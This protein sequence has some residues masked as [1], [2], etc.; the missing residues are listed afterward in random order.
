MPDLPK[1]NGVRSFM[2]ER[3]VD[4]DTIGG[5]LKLGSGFQW[6]ALCRLAGI[7]ARERHQPGGTE[8][9]DYL[10][11]LMF[12]VLW[13]RRTPE[14]TVAALH[15]DKYGGRFDALVY[16]PNG[17]VLN[18]QLVM[19]GYAIPW[20]GQGGRPLPEWPIPY[21][22]EHAWQAVASRPYRRWWPDARRRPAYS[23][24]LTPRGTY[25]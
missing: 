5:R 23:V 4:G 22:R 18:D 24:P 1:D 14:L 7:N 15:V 20:D 21:P 11:T 25:S 2:F 17:K 9:R 8:A 3:V 13:E 6:E 19:D 10:T 12:E 16:L